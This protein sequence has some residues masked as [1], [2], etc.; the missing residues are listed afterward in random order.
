MLLRLFILLSVLAYIWLMGL[1]WF[2]AQVPEGETPASLHAD[3]AVVLT[4]GVLRLE[5]GLDLLAHG[6][7][8][9]LFISGVERGVEVKALLRAVRR[10]YPAVPWG[11]DRIV[12]LGHDA[13]DTRGNAE[14]TARWIEKEQVKSLRL[15]TANYHMPRAISE[16][17]KW[18]PNVNLIPDPVFPEKFKRDSWWQYPGTTRLILL[19]YHKYVIRWFQYV[20]H[21]DSVHSSIA[22]STTKTS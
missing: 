22:S 11:S 2:I 19:E 21:W 7:V 1:V 20:T 12:V 10:E 15:V 16:F 8:D 5:Q 18:M 9:K 13:T 4:G 3:A 6:T 14:E 17:K